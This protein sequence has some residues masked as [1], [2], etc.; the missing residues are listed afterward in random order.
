M[1]EPKIKAKNYRPTKKKLVKKEQLYTSVQYTRMNAVG[2]YMV[3][4][5]IQCI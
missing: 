5:L 1:T 3:C 2:D 4:L